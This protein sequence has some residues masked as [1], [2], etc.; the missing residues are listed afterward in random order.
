MNAVVSI[1]FSVTLAEAA[2]NNLPQAYS[3]LE[4]QIAAKLLELEVVTSVGELDVLE[5]DDAEE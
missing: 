2:K 3:E 4:A 5:A 1:T